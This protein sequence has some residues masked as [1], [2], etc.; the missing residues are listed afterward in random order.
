MAKGLAAGLGQ[1]SPYVE[2]V[3]WDSIKR[4]VAQDWRKV[5]LIGGEG[6]TLKEVDTSL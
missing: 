4:Y 1:T 5:Q 6:K 3:I 2:G